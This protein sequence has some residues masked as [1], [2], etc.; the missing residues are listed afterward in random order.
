M[1]QR[2]VT[3]AHL[4]PG[5]YVFK[6]VSCN[7]SGTW[8]KIAAEYAFEILSP[9]W[10]KWWFRAGAAALFVFLVSAMVYLRICRL[11]A[12]H[13]LEN[14]R[15]RMERNIIELEQEAARLQMNPHF[16]FNSLNSIQGFIAT[17]NTFEAKKYIARFA[18]LMRLILENAREEF[19][20]LAN[21]LDILRNYLELEQL[22]SGDK[23]EFAVHLDGS[24]DAETLEIPPMMI[25]PFVENAIIHGIRKKEGRGLIE[26]NFR[27]EGPVV[28]CE[29][30][31]NGIGRKQSAEARDGMAAGHKSTG[32]NVT[33]KRLEQ[34]KIQTGK[35]AGIQIFDLV[36]NNKP[37]VTKVVI[38]I[39]YE[40]YG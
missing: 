20:P 4:P 10:K 34:L 18:R 12:K 35:N 37:A 39:P 31:D 26:L 11:K 14:D 33:R 30:T 7:E 1:N 32:I 23:F 36:E 9:V 13:K 6:G 22:S 29:I 24:I 16:I 38:S 28:V 19:I 15:L 5:K 40:T 2:E 21:E 27:L 17:E 25:Q 8:N 3:Y